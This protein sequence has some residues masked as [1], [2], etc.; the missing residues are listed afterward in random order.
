MQHLKFDS[1]GD[2]FLVSHDVAP[3]NKARPKSAG[4]KLSPVHTDSDYEDFYDQ[5]LS[6]ASPL[7]SPKGAWKPS[8]P[9]QSVDN[10]TQTVEN[11][12]NS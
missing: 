12:G 1:K 10:S 8:S 7:T 4:E 2:A 6:R 5:S 3:Q 11:K 9:P